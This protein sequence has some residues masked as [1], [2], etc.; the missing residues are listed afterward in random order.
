MI[1]ALLAA[2]MTARTGR[3]PSQAYADLTDALG[4][5]FATRV[6]AKADARQKA[7]LSKLAPEQVKST[8]LAGEP[9]VQI[10]SHAP[11]NG[12]AIGGLKVMTANGWFAAR[13][14]VLKT[15]IRSTLKASSTRRICS[16][17]CRKHKC[18]SMKQLPDR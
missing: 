7:L 4:K 17:W 10:L 1:P 18:W 14:R 9:I 2:E 16:V 15:S 11:G 6:E 5:P 8:E 12:Q 3:N 13:R